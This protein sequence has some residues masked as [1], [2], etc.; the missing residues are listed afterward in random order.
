MATGTYTPAEEVD[1]ATPLVPLILPASEVDVAV[2]LLGII[3][4]PA[5]EYDEALPLYRRGGPVPELIVMCGLGYKSIPGP[6][7][8]DGNY[9]TITKD[10]IPTYSGIPVTEGLIYGF[11]I[12]LKLRDLKP[13]TVGI[14]WFRS[15]GGVIDQIGEVESDPYTP[16]NGEWHQF[17]VQG[18]PPVDPAPGAYMIPYVRVTNTFAD[19]PFYMAGAHVYGLTGG[20]EVTAYAP[21]RYITLGDV[22][23]ILGV[24]EEQGGG[25]LLGNPG[26]SPDEKSR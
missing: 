25:F 12:N 26:D 9:T 20:G 8:E 4:T 14:M 3:V 7:D 6:P 16:P 2:N 15:P 11:S 17:T 13:T 24:D 1:Q 22:D 10:L 21:D 5:E 23:E 18:M 19:I